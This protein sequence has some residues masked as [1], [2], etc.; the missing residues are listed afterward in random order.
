MTPFDS[1]MPGAISNITVPAGMLGITI[2]N[3]SGYSVQIVTA[4][5]QQTIPPL[6]Y[7]TGP[8]NPFD[9]V[10]LTLGTLQYSFGGPAVEVNWSGQSLAISMTPLYV[11]ISQSLSPLAAD[12]GGPVDV[13]GSSVGLV[14]GTSLQSIEQ[15]IQTN[16]LLHLGQVSIPVTD[17]ANTETVSQM[18]TGSPT[19]Y[20][21][22]LVL[23][24]SSLNGYTYTA[25]ATPYNRSTAL[26]APTLTQMNGPSGE[27]YA[28]GTTAS[29]QSF[30]N[31]SVSLQAD[32]TAVSTIFTDP[33]T[34]GAN[35]STVSGSVTYGASGA[36]FGA[37][38]TV[39]QETSQT[40]LA[41]Q[42][43][44]LK[45]E[46][47]VQNTQ[48]TVG[49]STPVNINSSAYDTS[50]NG[51]RKLVLL[52]NGWIVAA[53]QNDSTKY[54]Y[55]YVSKDNGQTWAQLCYFNM[56]GGSNSFAL[57]SNGTVVYMLFCAPNG[58][59]NYA[60]ALDATTVPNTDQSGSYHSP[61]TGQ[62]SFGNG[63]SIAVDGNGT[64][65][66]VWCSKNTTYSYSFNLRYSKSSD[67]GSTWATPTQ[68]TTLNNNGNNGVTNPC[69]VV[70]SSN[71][72][73]IFAV[74]TW[75]A[76]I[77]GYLWNGSTFV[78]ITLVSGTAVS[79]MVSYGDNVGPCAAID[80]NGNIEVV[81]PL[82]TSSPAVLDIYAMRSTNGGSAWSS[83]QNLTNSPTN[84]YHQNYPTVTSD[85]NNNIDVYLE[86]ID[87]SISTTYY[88]IRH[89]KY[90][91]SL[92]T[93]GSVTSITSNTS[94]SAENPQALWSEYDMNCDYILPLIIYENVQNTTTVFQGEWIVGS[95]YTVGVDYFNTSN[96]YYECQWDSNN[97]NLIK[98]DAGTLTT[99]ATVSV[100]TTETATSVSLSLVVTSNGNLTGKLQGV[101]TT[102]VTATDTAITSGSLAVTGDAGVVAS[103]A[104]ISGNYIPSDTVTVDV[105]AA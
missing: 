4:T 12:I 63:C 41:P 36:T 35:W 37:T 75:D 84:G 13:S 57:A 1:Y 82:Q 18:M 73:F 15:A 71:S 70:N 105:Y 77:E 85:S 64:L 83:P 29:R 95:H 20:Y 56:G 81:V 25:K 2:N 54:V 102:T 27:F 32:V 79:A 52:S 101:D 98:N 24:G 65:H 66:A 97:L 92:G 94:N 17:L 89:I 72:P 34:S 8:V 9:G 51:G 26:T 48:V 58:T 11:G 69:L 78:A 49:T 87:G 68:I 53:A 31:V 7:W 46:F 21:E 33:M 96:T 55:W 61:D 103:N 39:L 104:F 42:N 50:G 40:G 43:L 59:W 91:A 28:D 62:S 45:A 19:G 3:L 60:Y 100:P 80:H 16:A 74:D 67:G 86:G 30:S 10:T 22:T 6:T 90:T 38:P 93:W 88:Q 47:S 14:S 5:V 76:Y 44:T 23:E 99:L